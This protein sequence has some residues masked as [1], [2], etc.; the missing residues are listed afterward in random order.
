METFIAIDLGAGSGRVS[1]GRFKDR[2]LSLSE[3]HRFQHEPVSID[4]YLL[5]NWSLIL[6]EIAK[7]ISE[8]ARHVD[9]RRICSISCSSWAQ[10][11]GF[12]DGAGRLFFSPV[13]Y[14]DS[15]TDGLPYSF[16]GIISPDELIKRTGVGPYPMVTLC[17]LYALARQKPEVLEKASCLLHIAD[18]L[19]YKMCGEKCADW[20]LATA[21]QIRNLVSGEWDRALM[22]TLDIP[23]HFLPELMEFPGYLGSV[24]KDVFPHSL[25]GGIPVVVTAG[26]DTAAATV[27]LPEEKDNLFISS[28]TWSMMGCIT[29]RPFVTDKPSRH[30]CAVMGL[31]LHRWGFLKGLMGMWI[32]QECSKSWASS[33]ISL[34]PQELQESAGTALPSKSVIDPDDPFFAAE[35]GDMPEKI[36]TFCR[37]TGQPVPCT[38]G[39]IAATVFT[40]MVFNYRAS[41]RLIGE[42][43]G[44]QFS[45]VSII[46]G[47]GRNALLCQMTADALGL[48]V[49]AGPFESTTAGNIFVQARVAG[50]LNTDEEIGEITV[51]SFPQMRYIPE[52][53]PEEGL[54][55]RFAAIKKDSDDGQN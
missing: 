54:Y 41:A 46:G 35:P 17:Q 25:L 34:D 7:G 20:T 32:L 24:R 52:K 49:V 27:V 42:I 18:L 48:P 50:V 37:N 38:V 30:G 29:G 2:K 15:Q 45:R 14:R 26:H 1:A 5:W 21:S 19:H 6:G 12:L 22:E 9:C 8:T 13:S 28:G 4:G 53:E 10:D 16:S 55:N 33:G 36:K 40:G 44:R 3:I 11:F 47:A 23:H 51:G 43:T 31:G 39:E